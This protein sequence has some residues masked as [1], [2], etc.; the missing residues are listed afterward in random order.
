VGGNLKN[1][2][3]AFAAVAAVR[4][5]VG[6]KLFSAE[7][8]ASRAAITGSRIDFYFIDKAHE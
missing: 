3:A 5:A 4:A 1:E 7:R 8:D 2:V 6:D